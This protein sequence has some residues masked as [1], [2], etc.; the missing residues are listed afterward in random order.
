MNILKEILYPVAD[1]IRDTLPN[2]ALLTSTP[3]TPL[4]GKNATLDSMA[5]FAFLIAV[6]ERL[7]EITGR[8]IRVANEKAFSRKSSPFLTMNTLASYIEQLLQENENI[9]E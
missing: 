4:F 5:L 1:E 9:H 7:E 2:P 6:E 3:E 8:S